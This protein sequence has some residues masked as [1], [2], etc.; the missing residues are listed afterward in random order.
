MKF[1]KSTEKKKIL[2]QLEKQFGITKLPFLL[3][4]SGKEKIRGFTGDLT[5]EE[6]NELDQILNIEGLG[7]YLVKIEPTLRLSFDA[8]HI[9][10]DQIKKGIIE[11][12]DE[13]LKEWIRGRDLDIQTERG[14]VII[15]HNSDLIG[16]GKSN[17]E[18]IINHIPKERRLK[19]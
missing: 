9:L 12:N 7:I 17:T 6:I 13:Q 2:Q 16:S 3:T 15:K 18:K 11:I 4:K 8:A 14:T 1:V 19:K 10:K 5:R